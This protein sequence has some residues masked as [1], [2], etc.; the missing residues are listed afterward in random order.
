MWPQPLHA[1]PLP[2]LVL[3]SKILESYILS[4]RLVELQG[5]D[6]LVLN[7]METTAPVYP[8]DESPSSDSVYVR[9]VD[10]RTVRWF[11]AILAS[12]VGFQIALDREQTYGC[13]S[14]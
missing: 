5:S 14:P 4:T 9:A 8:G 11:A 1:P 7:Y 3:M 10:P 13:H 2:E 6:M 12:S